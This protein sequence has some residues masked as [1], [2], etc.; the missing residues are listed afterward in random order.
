MRD[1]T[2]LKEQKQGAVCQPVR[3]ILRKE[4]KRFRK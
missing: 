3:K 2:N 4:M 1:F